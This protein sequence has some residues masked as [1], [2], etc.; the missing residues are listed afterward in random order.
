MLIKQ[1]PSMDLP[2]QSGHICGGMSAGELKLFSLFTLSSQ[3]K[4]RVKVEVGVE[5]VGGWGAVE[6]LRGG[7][8]ELG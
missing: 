2:Q 6:G 3:V 1:N 7:R 4:E 5:A 8:P